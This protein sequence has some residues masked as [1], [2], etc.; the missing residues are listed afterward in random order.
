M[1][2]NPPTQVVAIIPARYASERL[3]GKPLA[4]I[5]GKAMIQHVY[6]RTTKAKCINAVLVATD[7]ERIADAVRSFGGHAVMTP[8]TLK[9]GSDRIAYV[10]AS[11]PDAG[12]IVNVQ[13]DE[14]L[15]EPAMID[16]AVL[17]LLN[18]PELQVGTLVRKV[19]T[20][21]ELSNP[22]V[23]KVV[24]DR[25]GYALYFSRSAAP[26]GRDIPEQDWLIRH[27]Y[28]KHIGL[29]VFRRDFLLKFAQMPQTPLE[30]TEK[31]EQLRIL[32]NGYKI[33]ATVT[34]HDSISVDTPA[35]L[36]RVR[37]MVL[38]TQ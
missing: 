36:E 12:I 37:T 2:G 7:D 20:I 13:G 1:T 31:L 28:Y 21:A 18:K 14:P 8:A 11:L 4:D 25:E 19:E 23:V 15:I 26:Y 27:M 24:C 6:E 9:S 22:N 29:Y 35:D 16:E 10:A 33:K 3:P 32:E 34:T 17:P 30:R 38:N 5:A